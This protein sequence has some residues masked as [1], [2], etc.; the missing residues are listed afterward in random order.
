MEAFITYL[1]KSYGKQSVNLELLLF[2]YV[3]Y[4]FYFL[5]SVVVVDA[6]T[7]VN[8]EFIQ[9]LLEFINLALSSNE[10]TNDS[11]QQEPD[12][13]NEAIEK[14]S[15]AKVTHQQFK[16]SCHVNDTEIVLLKDPRL[17]IT[18]SIVGHVCW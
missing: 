17:P 8:L 2:S 11:T 15:K 6:R 16:V 4:Y 7:F 10:H 3:F 1:L 18:P 5:V 12:T 13:T 9:D 14:D